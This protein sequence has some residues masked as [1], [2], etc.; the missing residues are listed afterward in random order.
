MRTNINLLLYK[1]K[2]KFI[3]ICY[4]HYIENTLLT[5]IEMSRSFVSD[6]V[7]KIMSNNH[8]ITEELN[9]DIN[10]I[11]NCDN[12]TDF[13]YLVD[14]H[15]LTFP[16]E[17]Y[18]IIIQKKALKIFYYLFV[19]AQTESEKKKLNECREYIQNPSD[20]GACGKRNANSKTLRKTLNVSDY[21]VVPQ[22]IFSLASKHDNKK[23][24]QFIIACG[25]PIDINTYN[26]SR[27]DKTGW[28]SS[29]AMAMSH[30]CKPNE[31]KTLTILKHI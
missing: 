9:N 30:N 28:C 31:H 19:E 6:S 16:P 24:L 29:L 3:N 27:K 4:Y 23:I 10:E 15:S 18:S 5:I 13:R 25:V 26:E 17:I 7:R 20:A 1:K 14:E 11:I 8:E 22:S 21:C 12:I 2:M